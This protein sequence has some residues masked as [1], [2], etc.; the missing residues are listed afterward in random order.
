MRKICF[1]WAGLLIILSLLT[2]CGSGAPN[3]GGKVK[4]YRAKVETGARRDII[5]IVNRK[6]DLYGYVL[7][8]FTDDHLLYFETNW[9]YRQ[10][11]STQMMQ[12]ISNT[13]T[14]LFLTTRQRAAAH[15]ILQMTGEVQF[16]MKETGEWMT[17]DIDEGIRAHFET[18]RRAVAD[19]LKAVLWKR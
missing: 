6:L 13:R 17:P 14:R 2:A 19:D 1:H 16:Q 9:Q 5:E 10:P 12:G 4:T 7:T 18:F 3:H 8:R 15:S 11:N